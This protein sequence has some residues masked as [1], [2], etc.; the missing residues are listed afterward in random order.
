MLAARHPYLEAVGKTPFVECV[1]R[2]KTSHAGVQSV[3]KYPT[4][5]PWTIAGTNTTQTS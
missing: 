4:A 3:W 5:H 1:M 2:M